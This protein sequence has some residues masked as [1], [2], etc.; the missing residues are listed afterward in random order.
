M[1]SIK[2]IV[3]DAYGTLFNVQ[4]IQAR[5]DLHFGANAASIGAKWRQKQLEYTWL[6]SLMN[7]YKHFDAL[8][9]DALAFACEAAGQDLTTAIK[10]DLMEA[11]KFIDVFFEVPHA[12]S[13]L[14]TNYKLAILSNA[15]YSLLQSAIQYNNIQMHF[16]TIMSAEEVGQFKTKPSVYQLTTQKLNLLTEEIAFVSSNTWDVAGAKSYGLKVIWLRR[17]KAIIEKLDFLP[18]YQIDHLSQ[19]KTLFI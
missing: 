11:Y 8:T 15:N 1:S 13:D 9:I 19:L 17:N 14:Q 7:R 16:D 2:A 5:L 3:F 4:S 18:D 12:L 6:R 10:K